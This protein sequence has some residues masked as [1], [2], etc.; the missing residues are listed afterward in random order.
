MGVG[1]KAGVG[2]GRL[3]AWVCF[4]PNSESRSGGSRRVSSLQIR[5]R[6]AQHTHAHDEAAV[7]GDEA[8]DEFH[9]MYNA[10]RKGKHCH[11]YLDKG[12]KGFAFDHDLA[13]GDCLVFH[14]TERAKFKVRFSISSIPWIKTPH[15]L[16]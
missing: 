9:M 11:Y 4:A 16:L 6:G 8:D 2:E 13:D 15:F 10:H 14:M 7:L 1:A 3:E 12:W 5:S